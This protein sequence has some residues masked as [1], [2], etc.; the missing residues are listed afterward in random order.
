MSSDVRTTSKIDGTGE[1]RKDKKVAK[2]APSPLVTTG[3]TTTKKK[4]K[5]GSNWK[6]L[7]R[8]RERDTSPEWPNLRL[9]M[10]THVAFSFSRLLE[11]RA[12]LHGSSKRLR[13][14]AVEGRRRQVARLSLRHH[15]PRM[16]K[17]SRQSPGSPMT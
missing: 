7:Q 10:L 9:C 12:S 15:R 1:G 6:K 14:S 17:P 5:A 8:V 3:G 2:A 16:A 11:G 13:Q 4:V